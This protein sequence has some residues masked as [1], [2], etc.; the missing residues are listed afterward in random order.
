[1]FLG[2]LFGLLVGSGVG[3]FF[4]G[5]WFFGKLTFFEFVSLLAFVDS[6]NLFLTFDKQVVIEFF[7]GVNWSE[8]DGV[9]G[10]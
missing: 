9:F 10:E 4:G 1:M 7:L 5:F 6:L 8:E 2:F 3:A